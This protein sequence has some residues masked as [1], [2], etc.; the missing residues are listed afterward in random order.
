M[1]MALLAG[2]GALV[3]FVGLWPFVG[4]L[5]AIAV[6]PFGGSLLAVAAIALA[7]LW[8][9]ARRYLGRLREE[10]RSSEDSSAAPFEGS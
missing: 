3:T 7:A 6:A 8:A 1:P 2:V 4:W 10:R 9:R 5:M